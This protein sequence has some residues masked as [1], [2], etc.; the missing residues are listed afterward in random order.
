M[1]QKSI[2]FLTGLI[3]ILTLIFLSLPRDRM[4]KDIK[5]FNGFDK[6]SPESIV[7]VYSPT[8]PLCKKLEPEI[9]A[10]AESHN[11]LEGLV[12]I[13]KASTARKI[14]KALIGEQ[15]IKHTPT[16]LVVTDNE[17][18]KIELRSDDD[19]NKIL[20]ENF[21]RLLKEAS[22]KYTNGGK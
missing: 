11:T 13:R 14:T 21:E 4:F 8:C 9:N 6:L 18:K 1:K 16:L 7:I 17:I 5:S 20:D 19:V 3:A 10:F 15:E 22:K 12:S 2:I